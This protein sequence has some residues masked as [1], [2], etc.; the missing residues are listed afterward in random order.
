MKRV[1]GLESSIG[2]LAEEHATNIS[3]LIGS[4]FLFLF[5]K[6]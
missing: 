5:M 1:R 6:F 4:Q 2:Y 3:R